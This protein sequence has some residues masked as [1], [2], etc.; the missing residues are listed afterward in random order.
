MSQAYPLHWPEGWPR[1]DRPA[2]SQFKTSLAGAL[3]NVEG[4]IK[5]FSKDSGKQV[6]NTV[7]S[8]NVTLGQQRPKD[9]GV[10]IYF[11]WDGITTCIAVDRY[12]KVEDNLQAIHHCIEAERT[13]LRH[14][15]INLVRAAFRGY[16]A[17]PPP[18]SNRSW[19]D[20]LECKQGASK[21]IIERQYKR[22]R[23]DHHPDKG[24]DAVRFN[25]IQVAYRQAS[26][27]VK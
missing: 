18:T 20:V 5:L 11:E 26:R 22:L 8:S 14:G 25:E 7:I 6:T 1:N 16:A 9:S 12:I 27:E 2:K 13:K 17:L 4:S 24:G 3:K 23:S 10:A 19:W 21:A 15:G